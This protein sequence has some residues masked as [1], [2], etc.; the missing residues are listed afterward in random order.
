MEQYS[1]LDSLISV[2][3]ILFILSVIVEKITQLIRR[4]A[5]FIKPGSKIR[6]TRLGSYAS[7]YWRN[8]NKKQKGVFPEVDKRVERE[9]TSLSFVIGLAIALLFR[10][11][12]FKMFKE[13]DPRS[14]L[15]WSDTIYYSGY[16]L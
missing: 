15:F 8:I 7:S 11:D 3:I 13:P 16:E 6:K 9:V 4:Y 14:V 1:I 12:L 10:V 2:V 5:P